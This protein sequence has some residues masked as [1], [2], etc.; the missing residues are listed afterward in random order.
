MATDVSIQDFDDVLKDLDFDDATLNSL[1]RKNLGT[2]SLEEPLLPI[3]DTVKDKAKFAR[4]YAKRV[5][6]TQVTSFTSHLR[7][8]VSECQAQAQRPD[9]SEF[10]N[11]KEPF[12]EAIQSSLDHML[13]YEPP[14]VTA[15]VLSEGL[16]NQTEG[17]LDRVDEVKSDLKQLSVVLLEQTEQKYQEILS[18]AEEMSTRIETR[19]R[20]TATGVSVQ[21]AQE[22][23]AKAQKASLIQIAIWG[24]LS[25]SAVFTFLFL[26]TN[27]LSL[28]FKESQS[29]AQS[30][31]IATLRV[32]ALGLIASL[33]AYFLNIL[34]SQLHQFQHNLHRKRLANCIGSF[35]ESAATPHQRDVIYTQLVEAI[36]NFGDSGLLKKEGSG[37]SGSNS[38]IV[39]EG[40]DKFIKTPD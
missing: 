33:G 15:A 21:D 37:L 28:D 30:I 17:V 32:A 27:L 39:L 1:I 6:D 25:A 11:H 38:K 4:R 16:L 9:S 3:L 24:T 14:F 12:L 34:R 18:N 23:F 5:H 22:Q 35:V 2:E 26:L 20:E 8:F 7:D 36:T 29:L 40:L 10:I 13:M 31:Y 19:A